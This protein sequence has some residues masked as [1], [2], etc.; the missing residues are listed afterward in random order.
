M[1]S[2]TNFPFFKLLSQLI[3]TY[4]QDLVNDFPIHYVKFRRFFRGVWTQ[5]ALFTF[6]SWNNPKAIEES[7]QSENISP[8]VTRDH[9]NVSKSG[10]RPR[11][12]PVVMEQMKKSVELAN[13]RLKHRDAA[14]L[15]MRSLLK[16][17]ARL[18]E[19]CPS[20]NCNDYNS[21]LDT[22]EQAE[23]DIASFGSKHV[24][25]VEGLEFSGRSTLVD[26]IVRRLPQSKIILRREVPDI[27]NN[28]S[29]T[30]CIAWDFLEN[31]RIALE[32][33]ESEEEIFLVENYF[34]FFLTKYLQSAAKTEDDVNN[35]P[36]STFSWP[37]D[38][39]IPE[40][41]LFLTTTTEI[42]LSRQEDSRQGPETI[43][44]SS[45]SR[46]LV[47]K[48][49]VLNAIF[50]AIRGPSTVGIDTSS[51]PAV[52]FSTVLE[53]LDYFGFYCISRGIV[54]SSQHHP[55]N[56]DSPEIAEPTV[57]VVHEPAA[58]NSVESSTQSQHKGHQHHS[59][60]AIDDE[61]SFAYLEDKPILTA[62]VINN[63]RISMGRVS[64]GVYGMYSRF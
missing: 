64:L 22:L 12:H 19:Y 54:T 31:Y 41:V 9:H 42:R 62:D 45:Q 5:S 4:F 10:L 32:I 59:S 17:D 20:F 53:A 36:Y 55:I 3:E 11:I 24:L 61:Y 28:H 16:S 14:I 43:I 60:A 39:P 57:E 26:S 63:R 15:I 29:E 7:N 1:P 35:F 47:D 30:V 37:Y 58:S 34:H 49:A 8:N 25:G 51:T 6:L 23:I 44:P 2:G 52:V 27:I 21:F 13:G 48:D 18:S 38:L 40:L 46:D 50:A 33:I 56:S